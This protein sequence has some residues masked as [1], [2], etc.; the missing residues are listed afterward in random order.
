MESAKKVY[1]LVQDLGHNYLV[2]RDM[3]DTMVPQ[4]KRAS[5][6]HHGIAR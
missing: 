3:V 5:D 4:Q 2:F 6:Q 1:S